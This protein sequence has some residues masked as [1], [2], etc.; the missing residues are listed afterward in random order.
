MSELLEG[1][2]DNDFS[3]SRQIG[4]TVNDAT[5]EVTAETTI[6]EEV[7]VDDENAEVNRKLRT[8]EVLDLMEKGDG[9]DS[10]EEG[11]ELDYHNDAVRKRVTLYKTSTE[12][13]T[14]KNTPV[15]DDDLDIEYI[16]DSVGEAWWHM[17]RP[18]AKI[19]GAP[20]GWSP[21]GIPENWSGYNPRN[22]SGAPTEE[23][24]DNPGNWNLY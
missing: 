19:L 4:G 20:D 5:V 9:G 24:I 2:A 15:S 17:K 10:D 8:I 23:D 22:N 21:P 1:T 11:F 7:T 13:A 3:H 6:D 16:D 18:G 12:D 14:D